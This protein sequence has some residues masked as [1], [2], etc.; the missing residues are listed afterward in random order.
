MATSKLSAF[1]KKALAHITKA[2]NDYWKGP[3]T[4]KTALGKRIQAH[5]QGAPEAFGG[6][7]PQIVALLN[8]LTGD[9]VIPT[10]TLSKGVITV[11]TKNKNSHDYPLS[12]PVMLRGK[13]EAA[14]RLDG[15]RGNSLGGQ[16][17]SGCR[18]PSPAEILH[19]VQECPESSLKKE[20]AL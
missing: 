10:K 11:P 5:L 1:Q 13:W 7:R 2:T 14:V 9:A 6:Y 19:F 20:L 4:A 18:A 17:D 12:A 15:T 3:D 8:I 16:T